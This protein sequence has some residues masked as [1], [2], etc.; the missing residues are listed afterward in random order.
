MWIRWKSSAGDYKDNRRRNRRDSENSERVVERWRGS[1]SGWVIERE[2]MGWALERMGRVVIEGRMEGS[3]GGR[4][5]L[6]ESSH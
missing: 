4:V 6:R 2:T 5:G 3:G 1:E